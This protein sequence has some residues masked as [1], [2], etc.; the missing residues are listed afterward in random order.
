MRWMV[1]RHGIAVDAADPGVATDAERHL[2]KKGASRVRRIAKSLRVADLVPD[3]IFT[4][5]LVRA[6]ETA[7][8]VAETVGVAPD[9]VATTDALLPSASPTRIRS[10]LAPLSAGT[11]LCVG[12]APHLDLLLA[13]LLGGAAPRLAPLKKGGVAIVDCERGARRPGMLV[14]LLPP[15]L[16]RRSGADEGEDG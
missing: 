13:A 3:R 16:L 1:M 5:P 7:A 15:R 8:I 4:S 11:V 6:V 9:R 12:H 14:A 2:T 10:E